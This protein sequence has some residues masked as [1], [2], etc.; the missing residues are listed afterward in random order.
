MIPI[1]YDKNEKQFTSNGIGRLADSISCKVTEKRNSIYQVTL[2]YPAQ[3]KL[4]E[5]IK[6]GNIVF[7]KTNYKKKCH[8]GV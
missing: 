5:H 1:L 4:S 7:C 6:V 3:G 8:Y 2:E